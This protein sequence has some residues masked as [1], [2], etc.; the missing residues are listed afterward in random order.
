MGTK[1]VGR[2]HYRM[3]DFGLR[4]KKDGGR[5]APQRGGRWDIGYGR[6]GISN[7]RRLRDDGREFQ[8]GVFYQTA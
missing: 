1:P 2:R 8:W 7:L 6:W 5:D 3:E 4:I